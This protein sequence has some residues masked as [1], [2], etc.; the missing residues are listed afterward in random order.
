MT[1]GFEKEWLEPDGSGGFASGT[2]PG[3][4]TRR[5]HALLLTN[6]GERFVL[7]N[8]FEAWIDVAGTTF[9][10]STQHY[11]P[12]VVHPRGID[13]LVAFTADPWPRWTFSLPDGT[14]VAHE[15]AVTA[16]GTA[17][18]WRRIAGA[19]EASRLPCSAS[20]CNSPGSRAVTK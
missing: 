17:C 20:P 12:D 9:P 16:Q 4:R 2:A 15:L 14:S 3:Y 5:Y 7:V 1:S 8:G 10:L 13:H 6:T 18:A 11:A 19:G